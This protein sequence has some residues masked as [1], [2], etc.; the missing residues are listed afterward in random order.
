VVAGHRG[1]PPEEAA[2]KSIYF[3][4]P[5]E[6][7]NLSWVQTQEKRD[8]SAKGAPRN[9]KIRVFR[10]LF[11]RAVTRLQF[12]ALAVPHIDRNGFGFS[13]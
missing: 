10:G 11:S 12:K 3:V 4:I 2:E 5:N 6:V 8:S 13:R 1:C 7:R 9:D